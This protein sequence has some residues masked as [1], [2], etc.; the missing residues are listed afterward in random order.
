MGATKRRTGWSCYQPLA[1]MQSIFTLILACLLCTASYAQKK[2]GSFKN[3]PYTQSAGITFSM[4]W[5]NLYS[6]HDYEKAGPATKG[7]FVGLGLSWYYRKNKNKYSVNTGFTG[8]LPAPMGPI[9]FGKT[10]TRS[11]ISSIFVETNFH[12]SIYKRVG[13]ITGVNYVTYKYYFIDY[14]NGIELF[15][16]D[17]SLGLTAGL[18][19][20]SKRSFAL[21]IF[22]RPALVTFRT[23]QY[24]HVLS[25]DLRFDFPVWKK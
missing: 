25:M 8:D 14:D 11:S 4:P 2:K 21:A 9:S 12:H 18:E 5:G 13:F 6:Y 17:P 19:Y 20:L 3:A 15:K 23:K 7:G 10:G 1:T 16:Y 24:W 22:Y